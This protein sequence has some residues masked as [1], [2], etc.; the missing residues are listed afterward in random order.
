MDNSNIFENA[1]LKD[2]FAGDRRYLKGFL[3]KM[4]LIFL[5]YPDR[6]PRDDDKVVYVISRLYGQAMNWAATLIENRDPCLSNYE[7]FTERFKSFFGDTDITY[8]ANQKLRTLRQ[9]NLGG[10][11]GYIMEFNKYAD[12]SSWNEQAKM[13]AFIAGLND[14]VATR[15]LEMFPGPRNLIALQTIASRID[16][17]LSI[18]QHSLRNN[19][20]SY[21]SRSSN[22]RRNQTSRNKTSKNDKSFHGPLSKE[23]KDRR[24]REHLC[25]YCGSSSHTLRDCPKKNNNNESMSSTTLVSNPLSSTSVKQTNKS[26]FPQ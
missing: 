6:Y 19:S 8:I 7:V 23:E 12:D 5:L 15:I 18:N 16:T 14:Q 22:Y 10:V 9:R 26:E 13:D 17:R 11:H 3:A 4:E 1:S 20:S 21:G 25:L 2:G 24:R